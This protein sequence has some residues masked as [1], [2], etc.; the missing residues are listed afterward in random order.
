[1]LLNSGIFKKI[2]PGFIGLSFDKYDGSIIF[3][4]SFITLLLIAFR[5]NLH[6]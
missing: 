1:M 3:T 4:Y 5:I 2:W 6:L